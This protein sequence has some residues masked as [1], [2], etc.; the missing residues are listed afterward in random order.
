M[1]CAVSFSGSVETNTIAVEP[2]A[3]PLAGSRATVLNACSVVG[4][5]SGQ[6]VKPKKSS[7]QRPSRPC[8]GKADPSVRCKEAADKGAEPAMRRYVR[9]SASSGACSWTWWEG[10]AM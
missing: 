6:E 10:P 5:T 9:S 8:A 2:A 3:T 4:H 7:V 1:R